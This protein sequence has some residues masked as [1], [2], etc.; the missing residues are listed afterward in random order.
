MVLTTRLTSYFLMLCTLISRLFGFVRLGIISALM[1]TSTEADIVN[2]V[3]SIPNNLRKLLAEGALSSAFI[4]Q[5]NQLLSEEDGFKKSRLLAANL[6][7]FQ[8]VVLLPLILLAVFFPEVVLKPFYRFNNSEDALLG[9]NL[10]RLLFPYILIVSLSA[11][12]KAVLESHNKFI[13]PGLAPL[14]FSIAVITALL[15]LY[16]VFGVYSLAIGVLTGGITQYLF[17]FFP[18]LRLGY[19]SGLRFNFKDPAFLVVFRTWL[20]ILMTSSIFTVNQQIAIFLTSTISQIGAPSAVSYAIVFWQLPFG[21]F[22][23]TIN[24]LYFPKM[25]R[26]VGEKDYK[27]LHH[28]VEQA[29]SS[30]WLLLMPSALLLIYLAEPIVAIAFQRGQFDLHS[31]ILTASVLKAYCWGLFSV[32]TF[33]FSQRIFYSLKDSKT[34]LIIS[35]IVVCVDIVLSIFLIQTPLKVEGIAWAN[36][37]SFTLGSLLLVWFYLKRTPSGL[38]YFLKIFGKSVVVF[39][40]V[41]C[42]L[43]GVDFVLEMQGKSDW[44]QSGSDWSNFLLLFVIGVGA[45]SLI[46]LL[47]KIMK[48]KLFNKE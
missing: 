40:V 2:A 21:I 36:T 25:S 45:L 23:S 35:L 13:I 20:P 28:Y 38:S 5:F 15:L 1:G 24:T 3:F 9:A 10:F 39:V 22:S 30:L 42:Y 18:Y 41:F 37:I 7:G 29:L 12:V 33:N 32:A 17:Q 8:L 19:M 47:Y 26:S 4:P 44:W 48:V 6:Q 11:I 16:P 31:T 14:F 34:P 27:K 43:K 46:V